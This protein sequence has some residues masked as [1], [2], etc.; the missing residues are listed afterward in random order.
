MGD[1]FRRVLG[2]HQ[3]T[4]F[5]MGSHTTPP[6]EENSYHL[7]FTKPIIMSG[8]QFKMLRESSLISNKPKNIHARL[9]Q[10]LADRTLYQYNTRQMKY[11]RNIHS[12]VPPS[13][14]KYLVKKGGF[15]K[16]KKLY[17]IICTKKGCFKRWLKDLRGG[18]G[19][20]CE[21]PNTD[22]DIFKVDW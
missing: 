7:I 13:Y 20:D 4:I 6:C 12:I 16:K 17:K 11:I 15:A 9:E 14:N 10:P 3:E 21:I 18:S 1:I 22:K 5:Y 8:C 2:E 19:L